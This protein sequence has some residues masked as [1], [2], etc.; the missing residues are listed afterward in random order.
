MS[1][2]HD[3]TPACP[4][5]AIVDAADGRV[6]CTPARK[7]VALVGFA[8]SSRDLAPWLSPDHELWGM[9][10]AYEHFQRR[11]DR[12]FELHGADNQADI[13]VPTYH[14]DLTRL[15]CPVYMI[16]TDP[17]VP[18]SVRFPLERLKRT[19]KYFTSTAAYMVA[20]AIL[21]GFEEISLYGIDCTIG[22]EY[23][24]QKPC[25]E[26]WL[27]QAEG[28]GIRVGIPKTSALLKSP[29]MYGYEP[30]KKWPRVLQASEEFL[31]SRIATYKV[32]NNDLLK[33]LHKIEGAIQELEWI[34]TFAQARGRGA[35]FPDVAGQ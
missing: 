16:N 32:Q 13:A 18:T 34:V 31:Q 21:E 10:Q 15:G 8:S 5:M 14:E 35:E 6:A 30:T 1:T 20:L 24:Y 9:N 33:E 4:S 26:W 29:Y 17:K 11:P 27:G 19:R 12:W 3:V 23:E 22:G 28:A 2:W 25:L 7:K